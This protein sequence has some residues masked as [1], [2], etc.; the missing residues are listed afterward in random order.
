MKGLPGFTAGEISCL[1]VIFARGINGEFAMAD[2][3]LPWADRCKTDSA[4]EEK[5]KI[6]MARFK[7]LTLGKAV[8]MGW[9]TYCT[10]NKPLA[11]RWNIVIDRNLDHGRDGMSSEAGCGLGAALKM[12]EFNFFRTLEDALS[13]LENQGN[14]FKPDE[15]FLIGGSSLIE[16]LA[17]SDSRRKVGIV[18]ETVFNCAFEGASVFIPPAE[19]LFAEGEGGLFPPVTID[20]LVL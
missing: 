8:I 2:G 4:M 12:E 19:E 20:R 9:R 17:Q 5:R 16:K 7:R 14:G 3:S 1:N 13:F 11:G 15:V 10:F 18:Y 6:D